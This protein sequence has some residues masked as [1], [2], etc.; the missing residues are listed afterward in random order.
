MYPV[1]DVIKRP[2][3]VS[4]LA[5]GADDERRDQEYVAPIVITIS[6]QLLP[7]LRTSFDSTPN[8]APLTHA[9]GEDAARRRPPQGDVEAELVRATRT[10]ERWELRCRV[11]P[12]AA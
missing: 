4:L 6:A 10:T 5:E 9:V 8:R 7:M 3:A 12:I 2:G 1:I 11:E